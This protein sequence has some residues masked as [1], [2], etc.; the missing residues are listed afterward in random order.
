[1]RRQIFA[2]TMLGRNELCLVKNIYALLQWLNEIYQNDGASM[3][4]QIMN[5]RR[6]NYTVDE[7]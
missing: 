4:D 1:M 3:H 2:G 5:F 7:D 6:M